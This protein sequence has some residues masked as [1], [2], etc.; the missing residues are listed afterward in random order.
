MGFGLRAAGRGLRG[1]GV[2][3]GRFFLL[4]RI[5]GRKIALRNMTPPRTV[6]PVFRR[7]GIG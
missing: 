2:F 5:L 4:G 1:S 6:A 7:Q 3:L